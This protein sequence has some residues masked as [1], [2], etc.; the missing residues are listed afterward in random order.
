MVIESRSPVKGPGHDPIPTFRAL[1][2]L[3]E[4]FQI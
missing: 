3:K 4:C 2:G 1:A